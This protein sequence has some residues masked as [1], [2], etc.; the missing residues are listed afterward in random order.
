MQCQ[1]SQKVFTFIAKF[2]NF[3]CSFYL[4]KYHISY[5]LIHV[6]H[7]FLC[8]GLSVLLSSTSLRLFDQLKL[9]FPGHVLVLGPRG[10]GK[11]ALV[12]AAAKYFEDHKEILAHV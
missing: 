12:R 3:I 8:K 5:F 1:M 9:P 11:T 7:H 4:V 10:S 2:L 6:Y